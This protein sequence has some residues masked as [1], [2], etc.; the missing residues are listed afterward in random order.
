[1]KTET[2]WEQQFL[3]WRNSHTFDSANQELIVGHKIKNS[4]LNH[5]IRVTCY[6]SDLGY[7][8]LLTSQEKAKAHR[9]KLFADNRKQQLEHKRCLKEV[10]SRAEQALIIQQEQRSRLKKLEAGL[11]DLSREILKLREEYLKRRPLSRQGVA[12]L[13]LAISE[14]PKFIEQQTEQ[15]LEQ[16]KLL[17][18]AVHQEVETV[19]HMVKR[20]S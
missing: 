1:M 16:V 4:D 2:E 17:V 12:E 10:A 14:Q 5:N 6:R 3:A 18:G 15:L 13:V 9:E 7:K 8:V 11:A 20:I 19:H